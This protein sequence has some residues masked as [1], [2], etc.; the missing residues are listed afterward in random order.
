M[1][2]GPKYKICRR[3][4]AGVFEKCQTPKFVVSEGRHSVK[5]GTGRRKSVSEYGAQLIEK[6]KIRFTYGVSEK[7]FSNYVKEAVSAQGT[8]TAEKLLGRLELR[9]DNAAYRLGLA[10]TRAAARQMVS[11]GH[12]LVNGKRVT[13][14]SYKLSVGDV[15]GIREGS[16]GKGVFANLEAKLTDYNP[17]AW[18]KWNLSK[19]EGTVAAV[20]KEHDGFLDFHAVLEF[21]SR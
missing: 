8:D 20:P 1:I 19:L 6:Q 15:I 13:I 11:H 7:Q 10:G 2:T 16:R 18:L 17:P 5:K 3:L 14:P 12:L 4:G 21:Y 9:L